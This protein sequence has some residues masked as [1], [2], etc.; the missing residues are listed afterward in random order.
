MKNETILNRIEDLEKELR[1]LDYDN[2]GQ[3]VDREAWRIII[4]ELE[5]LR[6]EFYN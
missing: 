2:N 3:P 4:D 6:Q 1:T 5:E